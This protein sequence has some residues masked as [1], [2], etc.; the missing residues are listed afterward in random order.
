MALLLKDRVK[1]TSTTSGTGV[2]TLGGAVVGFQSFSA[3][4]SDSDTT[5]YAIAHRDAD[6]WEVGLGTYSAGTLSR[7]TI[8]E[9]SNAGSVVSFASGTKDVF[10][11]LPAEKAVVLTGADVL[12]V[13]TGSIVEGSNL[14]YTDTRANAAIDTRVT[15]T[16]VDGLLVDADTLDGQHGSYYTGYTD[17]QIPAV[18]IKTFVDDLNVDADTLDGQHGSYYTGYTDTAIAN[19]VDTAPATLDTLNEL[20]AALGDDPNF[21]TTVTNNIATKVSKAGDTMTGDLTVPNII[22]P[23]LVD[24]RDVSV[25]GA[26]LDGIEAGAT[27]DQTAGEILTAL[28]TVDGSGSGLDADTLDGLDSTAFAAASHTHTLSQIT[29]AGTAAAADTTDFDPA[30][31][32]VALAIALG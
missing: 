21:A 4:L 32:A 24:G 12:S 13:D 14:F 11:T 29:D 23:G 31:T 16:F 8:L 30:G 18:V 3:V 2:L 5:Y 17:T 20:A 7:D 15:K 25:D 1:E 27:G 9:S 10:I 19:L 6:E 22:T 28:L 26:K